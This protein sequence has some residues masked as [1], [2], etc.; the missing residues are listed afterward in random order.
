VGDPDSMSQEEAVRHL[1]A[2]RR[3]QHEV[4]AGLRE[5]EPVAAAQPHRM[6]LEALRF[7]IALHEWGADW[8]GRPAEDVERGRE[9]TA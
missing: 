5:H 2:M 1:G 6:K 4:A 7:G 3:R 9:G 8:Y